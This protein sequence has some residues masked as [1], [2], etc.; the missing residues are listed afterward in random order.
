MSRYGTKTEDG[1]KIEYGFDRVPS[2]GY[3]YQIFNG[4]G[5]LVEGG[6]TRRMM[7]AHRNEQHMNRSEIADKLREYD[8]NED[9]VGAMEKDLQF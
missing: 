4:D 5:E 1:G 8:V 7:V 3:F 9:H 2:S 6:D